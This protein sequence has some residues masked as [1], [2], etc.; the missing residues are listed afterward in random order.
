LASK[1]SMNEYIQGAVKQYSSLFKLPSHKMLLTELFIA[2]LFSGFLFAAVLNFSPFYL[3]IVGLALCMALFLV[4]LASDILV[5][6]T[7]R[8]VD[9]ILSF[10]RSTA[11]SLYSILVW[12]FLTTIGA[13]VNFFYSGVWFKFFVFGFCAALALRILVFSAISFAGVAAIA[14]RAVSLPILFTIP[15][16]Y[17][18]I[19]GNHLSIG[20]SLTVFFFLSGI[21][22]AVAAVLYVVSLNRVGKGI[23]GVSSFSVLKAFMLDWAEGENSQFEKLFEK[24]SKECDIQVSVLSFRGSDKKIKGMLV[25]PTFHPGPF[26]NVGSSALP[27]AI[28]T[29]LEGR[30]ENSV[31]AVP[32]GL[33]GHDMDLATQAQNRLVLDQ[34]LS[35]G[36]ISDFGNLASTFERV[37]CEGASVG[38]QIFNGCVLVTLTLAPKTMEDIPPELNTFIVEAA[39]K[40]GFSNAIS[41]DAHNSIKE[42]FEIEKAIKPLQEA[43]AACIKK[44]STRKPS[45]FQFGTARVTPKEFTLDD[46][47]GPG[48]IT[49]TVVKVDNQIAAYVTIDGNNMVSGLREQ[50]LTSILE[51]GVTTGEVFTTDTHAVNAIV[52]NQLGYHPIGEAMDHEILLRHVKLA[53]SA[54]L[55]NLQPAEV[56]WHTETVEKVK[57]IGER[58]I[59]DLC[60]LLD[61]ALKKARNLALSVFPIAGVILAALF[62]LL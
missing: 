11:L 50:I 5:R 52:L 48:G 35:F 37:E 44:A 24:S 43:A 42:P 26:K 20:A 6:F 14:F 13:V 57:V 33:S 7:S 38:C 12:L 58:Q 15:V 31:I 59:Q 1:A 49:A 29:A 27:Y 46:G 22:T 60:M 51:L 47:M 23:V 36:N 21:V 18:T 45:L 40:E 61:V 28:Q 3:V 4:T 39:Q 8:Q 54:A 34:V 9:P 30:V 16:V 55:K 2:C 32:H 17:S 56:A 41:I 62:L 19:T 10:R 53:V 25:V